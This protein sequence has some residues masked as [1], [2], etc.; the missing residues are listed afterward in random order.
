MI[1]MESMHAYCHLML[2]HCSSRARIA[3]AKRVCEAAPDT[4]VRQAMVFSHSV[5]HARDAFLMPSIRVRM[6]DASLP[7]TNMYDGVREY[8]V[9]TRESGTRSEKQTES[10]LRSRTED[11]QSFG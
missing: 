7:R 5:C 6:R 9:Q 1:A 11:C 4:L 3:G 8:H 10:E 2:D